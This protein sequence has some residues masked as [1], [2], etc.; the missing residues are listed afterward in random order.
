LQVQLQFPPVQLAVAFDGLG[1]TTLQPLQFMTSFD[2]FVSH[3]GLVGLQSSHGLWQYEPQFPPLQV[4]TECGGTGH[5]ALQAPQWLMLFCV[6]T[7]SL[8]HC[9]V[10]PGQLE[11]HVPLE[12]T[13][14]VP[15][16]TMPQPPQLLP[17]DV[18]FTH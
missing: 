13:V 4:A 15:P 9:C 12:Q 18:V 3:P 5:T 8:P 2:E 1:Q 6:F 16:H 7:Q 11:T 14:V 10:P 17:S